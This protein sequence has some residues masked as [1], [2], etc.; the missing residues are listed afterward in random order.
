[1]D[2]QTV[3]GLAGIA[4]TLVAG[5]G[6]IYVG[7]WLQ[8]KAEERNEVLAIRRAARL[9]DADLLMAEASA[10]ICVEKKHWWASDLRLTAE[11]WQKYRD[12]VAAQLSWNHWGA[13]VVAVEVIGHLQGSRDV[14]RKIQLA[15]MATDPETSDSYAAA[16]AMGLDIDDPAPAIP[17]TTVAQLRPWL[18][19]LEDGRRALASLTQTTNTKRRKAVVS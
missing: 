9:I 4:G 8:R 3:V 17:E 19:H 16:L 10:R 15:T 6:G 5:L 2:A 12:V 13:V 11:G 7:A 1:M 18:A 14:A